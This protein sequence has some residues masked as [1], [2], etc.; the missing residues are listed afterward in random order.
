MRRQVAA[1]RRAVTR[2]R[3]ELAGPRH[4]W[5]E[6]AVEEQ[7]CP[8]DSDVMDAANVGKN[9][10]AAENRLAQ[11]CFDIETRHLG[12]HVEALERR[13]LN[14]RSRCS[15]RRGRLLQPREPFDE[16]GGSRCV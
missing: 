15:K 13:G 2:C 4:V 5:L 10:R 16:I 6:T 9:A 14:S 12:R 11:L 1:L 7:K 8:I 3:R